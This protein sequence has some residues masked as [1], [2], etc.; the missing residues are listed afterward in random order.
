M[1]LH[2]N[3]TT[4]TIRWTAVNTADADGY[5]VYY[6]SSTE[7]TNAVDVGN[8]TQYTLG[9]LVPHQGY[10]ITVRA[11]Q[12]LL[13][14]AS[15]PLDVPTL[16]CESVIEKAQHSFDRISLIA[17][18]IQSLTWTL[19]SERTSLEVQYHV[20]CVTQYAAPEQVQW[21]KNGVTVV[22]SGTHTVSHQLL[23]D[24]TETINNTLTVMGEEH[25]NQRIACDVVNNGALVATHP[26]VN[27]E[28]QCNHGKVGVGADHDYSTTS[29]QLPVVLQWVW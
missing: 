22:S 2:K 1:V 25:Q 27:I 26:L 10:T 13:G 8:V 21:T 3:A 5:I 15:E 18:L 6:T 7:S 24:S 4:I 9:G 29:P 11:Y 28:G 23:S 14:P 20:Y 16:N 19:M 12:D 17:V